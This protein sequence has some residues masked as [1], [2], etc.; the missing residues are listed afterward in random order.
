MSLARHSARFQGWEPNAPELVLV[1]DSG[2]SV[3]RAGDLVESETGM[4][5]TGVKLRLKIKPN[6]V[7]ELITVAVAEKFEGVDMRMAI[8]RKINDVDQETAYRDWTDINDVGRWNEDPA[9]LFLPPGVNG[10]I[11]LS[12]SVRGDKP[13]EKGLLY[14]FLKARLWHN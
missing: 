4:L 13:P 8:G 10:A 12:L 11:N 1:Y 7:P 5:C 2:V 3:F 6:Y 14:Y 9:S